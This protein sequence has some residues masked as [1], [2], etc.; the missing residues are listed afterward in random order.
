MSDVDSR[1]DR[2]NG[3]A[4]AKARVCAALEWD[5]ADPAVSVE[6]MVTLPHSFVARVEGADGKACIFKQAG[7]ADFASS[8]VKELIVNRDV[9]G[10]FKEPVGPRMVA[11]DEAASLPWM[12]F[13]DVARDHKQ[14]S[15][16]PFSKFIVEQFVDAL[17]RTHAQARA[18]PLA[19]LF[20]RVR[21]DVLVTD[22][23]EAVPGV[24]DRFL[25]EMD[26]SRLPARSVEGTAAA[27][28]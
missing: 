5:V 21:G 14:V 7:S 18:L 13:E 2:Q 1:P 15:S 11:G 12:L 8:A 22:G 17:A 16:P 4:D 23:A 3:N 28:A 9:L 20:E 26:T 25:H 10:E 27:R 6:T 24:L 19:T